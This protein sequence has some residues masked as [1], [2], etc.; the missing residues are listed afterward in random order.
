[1]SNIITLVFW[2]RP[3]YA[4]RVLEHLAGCKGIDDYHLVI[5]LDGPPMQ[6]MHDVCRR[7]TFARTAEVKQF[8]RNMGCNHSTK[9]ALQRGF[10]LGDYVIHVEEDVILAPDSLRFFEWGEQFGSDTSLLNIAALHHPDGWLPGHG[11]FP[12]GQEVE[13]KVKREGGFSCWGWSTWKDRWVELEKNWSTGTD[14]GLSWD[15]RVEE[16]RRKWNSSQLMPYISRI[17]NIGAEGGVHRGDYL[18]PYWA[19]SPGFVMPDNYT[20]VT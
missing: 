1:M 8:E 13:K 15:V 11:P 10:E 19:G 7:L 20:L 6:Q 16:M 12:M 14:R 9:T 4:K 5:Q 3:Q 18:L 2:K 17:M